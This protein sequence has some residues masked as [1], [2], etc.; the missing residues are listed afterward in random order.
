MRCVIGSECSNEPFNCG[1]WIMRAIVNTDGA[2]RGNPG[3]SGAGAVILD[4]DGKE[5]V[6]VGEYI[7]RATNNE[8]EYHALLLGL[9]TA[10]KIGVTELECRVDS[11]L[12]AKQ[13]NGEFRVKKPELQVLHSQALRLARKFK[14]FSIQHVRREKNSHADR[15]AN[16]AIDEA[17]GAGGVTD[18]SASSLEDLAARVYEL[19]STLTGQTADGIRRALQQGAIEV[20][21][22]SEVGLRTIGAALTLASRVRCVSDDTRAELCS[23]VAEI[24]ERWEHLPR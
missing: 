2:C 16:E 7:G 22:G 3:D 5:I 21:A 8:A 4:V 24:A 19:A 13:I 6:T 14:S 12:I 20:Q 15:L 1:L 9:R 10:H 11:Q 17:I 23:L 18:K